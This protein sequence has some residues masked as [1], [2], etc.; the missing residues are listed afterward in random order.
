MRQRR[1]H[2][3]PAPTGSPSPAVLTI[4][5]ARAAGEATVSIEATVVAG[6]SLLDASGRRI[7]VQDPTGAV[8]VLLPEPR[9]VAVGDRYRLTGEMGTAY[10]APRFRATAIEGLGHVGAAIAA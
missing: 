4:A 9:T 7:V 10:N 8:E 1:P 5:G 3:R 2:R 6:S